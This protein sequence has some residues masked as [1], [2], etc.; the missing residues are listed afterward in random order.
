MKW[1]LM[2]FCDIHRS[3]PCLVFIP[4]ASSGS[5]WGCSN[6]QPDIM[7][8][9]NWRAPLGLYPQS[10]GNPTKEGEKKPYESE[11]MED[12]RKTWLTE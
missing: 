7:K 10:S 12:T 1:F 5:R 3:V 8:K 9:E 11:G 2:I 4:E 6:P